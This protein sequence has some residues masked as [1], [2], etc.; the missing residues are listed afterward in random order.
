[1]L[2]SLHFK[3]PKTP[4]FITTLISLFQLLFLYFFHLWPGRNNSQLLTETWSLLFP[5]L[6]YNLLL[7][8]SLSNK[9]QTIPERLS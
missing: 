2:I 4:S 6:R 1:M 3:Q 5:L 7:A 8:F 9:R